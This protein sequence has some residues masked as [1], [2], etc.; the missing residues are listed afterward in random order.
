MARDK[1]SRE[2]IP[3]WFSSIISFNAFWGKHMQCL[4][5]LVWNRHSE[6]A[7]PWLCQV[8]V[9]N[10]PV[11]KLYFECI[12]SGTP[13]RTLLLVVSCTDE[14]YVNI[15]LFV[16]CLFSDQGVQTNQFLHPDRV[17]TARS[18]LWSVLMPAALLLVSRPLRILRLGRNL[19]GHRTMRGSR[20]TWIVV[21]IHSPGPE[22][23]LDRRA[24]CNHTHYIIVYIYILSLC[25]SEELVSILKRPAQ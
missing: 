7:K 2:P 3:H 21:K 14:K 15:L 4:N 18:R 1:A 10:G 12:C 24:S 5:Q 16:R 20:I 23:K 22:R 11:A 19:S 9:D 13:R 8:F 6:I 17:V 25:S